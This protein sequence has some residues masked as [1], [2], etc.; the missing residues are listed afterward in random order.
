MLL[1]L[2]AR[3]WGTQHV[4]TLAEAREAMET[5]RFVVVL[6][7]ENLADGRGYDIADVV[8]RQAGSLYVGIRLSETL[9][10]PVVE[11]GALVLGQ[12]ALNGN[13]FENEVELAFGQVDG[14]ARLD[15][16]RRTEAREGTSHRVAPVKR[17]G[18]EAA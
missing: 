12:R 16:N 5:F 11:R 18:A 7:P 9:W 6:A 3:G 10:L 8:T 2:A 17:R 15:E 4:D 14:E 13:V 1:R